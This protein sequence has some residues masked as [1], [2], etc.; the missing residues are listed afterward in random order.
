MP[1]IATSPEE[2]RA[3]AAGDYLVK[4]RYVAAETCLRTDR[5]TDHSTSLLC[6][7]GVIVRVCVYCV[8][9]SNTTAIMATVRTNAF[10]YLRRQ[11]HHKTIEL[12]A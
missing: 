8:A 2:D 7:G 6:Q 11:K 5:P 9:L 3:T 12:S 1:C 4:F 10:V